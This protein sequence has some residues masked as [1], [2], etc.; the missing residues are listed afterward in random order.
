MESEE[1]ESS[2]PI[3]VRIQAPGVPDIHF[4]VETLDSA[5]I[6]AGLR[7]Q[8]SLIWFTNYTLKTKSGN[9]FDSSDINQDIENGEITFQLEVSP[10]TESDALQHAQQTA[11]IIFT[12][13]NRNYLSDTQQ[14]IVGWITRTFENKV[15]SPKELTGFIPNE[16]CKAT[17]PCIVKYLD[18]SRKE[19]TI[20][21][22]LLGIV[23]KLDVKTV[24]NKEFVVYAME[25]GWF[26]PGEKHFPCLHQFFISHSEFFVSC[27]E[28]VAS[29]WMML[30]AL[31]RAPFQPI[32]QSTLF[33]PYLVPKGNDILT[34]QKTKL[35]IFNV[36]TI[37]TITGPID[38]VLE[39]V[40]SEENK[41]LVTVQ[42]E[43]AYIKQIINGLSLIKSGS[44]ES[45]NENQNYLWNDLFFTDISN[46][47]NFNDRGG[48]QTTHKSVASDVMIFQY[49]KSAGDDVRVV[50]SFVIDYFNERWLV[51]SLIPG[52]ITRNAQIVHG[53][54]PENHT[55]FMIDKRFEEYFAKNVDNF[56][57]DESHIKG[58]DTPIFSTAEVNGVVGSDGKLYIVDMRRIS[59]R[60]ANYPDPKSHHSYIIRLEAL[61][62]FEK[63]SALEANSQELISL[64]G[65]K[66]FGYRR[67][68]DS[69]PLP[70][71]G[72]KRLND[73]RQEVIQNAPVIR[74]DVNAL[75]LDS[76]LT[77]VPKNI[78]DIASYIKNKL[79]PQ[80]ISEFLVSNTY[81]IDGQTIVTEMHK[82]GIN[83]R[84]IGQI[85]GF[86]DKEP[87]TIHI[88]AIKLII[89][90]EIVVRCLK[91]LVRKQ[92]LTLL[93]FVK[94]LNI[95]LKLNGTPS[96]YYG[97]YKDVAD[98]SKEKYGIAITEPIE[99]QRTSILRRLIET[100][101]ITLYS[102]QMDTPITPLMIAAVSPK[103]KFSN[104]ENQEFRDLIDIV[105]SCYSIGDYETAYVLL[106][107]ALTL[108]ERVALPL[109]R[110]LGTAYFYMSLILLMNPNDHELAMAYAL[111]SMLI[112]ER[113]NDQTH[114]EI[115]IRYAVLSD[116][117]KVLEKDALAYAYAS[118]AANLS[119]MAFPFHPW[120]LNATATAADCALA[121]D[122]KAALSYIQKALEICQHINND[123]ESMAR[124]YS[125][126]TYASISDKD[127][128]Q[129]KYFAQKSLEQVDDP[130]MKNTLSSILLEIRNSDKDHTS[131]F[132]TKKNMKAGRN[133]KGRK[134]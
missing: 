93:N 45:I 50:R 85:L 86:L 134:H 1:I 33:A 96:E 57:I 87:E 49:L 118:R 15:A 129:A 67:P 121:V 66:E 60:D 36:Q 106:N 115:I 73:K 4:N 102:Y 62:A 20:Q 113:Y 41:D 125:L 27:H 63:Y 32:N 55:T 35:K 132:N 31:E 128:H 88:K 26:I 77:E 68:P 53:F 90:S 22:H 38:D 64:G 51:Q 95:A 23:M 16:F 11:R 52:L 94:F 92:K 72:D 69:E 10:L 19:I 103:V 127:L 48:V 18:L 124:L 108:G 80:F 112:Q 3:K 114:P 70:E 14:S 39:T 97:L 5:T 61:K 74:Y 58:L 89:Q 17:Y 81:L 109:D 79:I 34:K 99:S 133:K 54:D 71:E 98:I 7:I 37:P 21:E 104:T 120:T 6:L 78:L 100:F 47:T 119:I 110:H 12:I 40:N 9:S 126:A 82:R 46:L 84:Y 91:A 83:V 75:T 29:K 123:K 131:E 101:G 30:M 65:V 56:R 59:P 117:A 28:L 42:I 2:K 8:P 130:N 76:N 116:I 43:E 13:S 25:D 24:E 107:R 44:I 111:K 122:P 105:S